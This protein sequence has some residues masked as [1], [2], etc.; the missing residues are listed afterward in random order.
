MKTRLIIIYFLASSLLIANVFAQHRGDNLAFQGLSSENDVGVR[1]LAMGGAFTSINNDINSLFYNAAGL[2]DLEDIQI[3][4][5]VNMYNKMWRENQT[6]RPNYTYITLPLYL[7]GLYVPDPK[8]NGRLDH[9]VFAEQ[10]LTTYKIDEPVTGADPFS[11]EAADW[12]KKKND[13]A[14]NNFA[15]AVPLNLANQK[16][17]V[18]A[19]YET[20]YTVQDFDR[21][22][23]HLDPFIGWDGYGAVERPTGNDSIRIDWSNYLRERSGSVKNIRGAISY[24]VHKN[25]NIGLGLQSFSGETD[26]IQN[27][28]R[29]GYFYLIGNNNMRFWYDNHDMHISGTSKYNSTAFNLGTIVTLS[30]FN[31]GLNVVAPYT[32]KREWDYTTEITDDSG[33]QTSSKSGEDELK[34]PATFTAGISFRPTDKFLISFDVES[35]PFSQAEFNFAS[36]DT[37]HRD[38]VDVTNI[39]FGLEY[40]PVEWMSVLAGYRNLPQTFVPDGA[41]FTDRGPG[42][43]SFT[44]GISADVFVGRLDVAY[45]IR[46]LKYYDSYLSN[47]NYVLEKFNNLLVSLTVGL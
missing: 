47:T 18:A 23:S 9:E 22:D 21:N 24:K 17:V 13:F 25:I 35:I 11:E 14:L 39:R 38:W 43:D 44:F 10:R 37:T 5:A 12:E 4:M 32:I 29:V 34:M 46:R 16:F 36:E 31:V 7:E 30:K 33:T 27:L 19:S 3:T 2:A 26:D 45:E 15:I 41:A 28:D 42:A 6:Y 8:N 20:K 40:K 1:S